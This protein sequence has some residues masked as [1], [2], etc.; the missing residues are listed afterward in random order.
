MDNE[1]EEADKVSD[2]DTKSK[3]CSRESEEA[4]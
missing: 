3:G 1:M 4:T 2:E